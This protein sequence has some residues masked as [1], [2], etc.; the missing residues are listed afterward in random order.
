MGPGGLMIC[1]VMEA[2]KPFLRTYLRTCRASTLGCHASA[3]RT[4]RNLYPHSYMASWCVEEV[5]SLLFYI[6]NTYNFFV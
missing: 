4:Q 2:W 6:K 3:L 1:I 5:H